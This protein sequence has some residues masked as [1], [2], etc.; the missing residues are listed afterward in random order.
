[1]SKIIAICN[2]KGG[3]GKTTTAISIASYVAMASR[4]TLLID[5]DPQANA[6]SGLGINKDDI[7]I[8]T[9]ECLL[10]HIALREVV[11]PTEI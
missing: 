2:Q 1:M 9:Y 4:R 10:D 11:I 5:L 3:V 8:S 7:S 6:T